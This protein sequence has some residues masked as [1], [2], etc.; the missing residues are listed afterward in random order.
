LAENAGPAGG[1][2]LDTSSDDIHPATARLSAAA[3]NGF[4]RLLTKRLVMVLPDNVGNVTPHSYP[5][6]RK[7]IVSTRPADIALW[8][9]N[10]VR[11]YGCPA[12][13]YISGAWAQTSCPPARHC[14]Q[15][16]LRARSLSPERSSP[17]VRNGRS[18][19]WWASA[20]SRSHPPTSSIR[21]AARR[22]PSPRLHDPDSGCPLGLH[23]W[24]LP[25]HGAT[26]RLGCFVIHIGILAERCGA[27]HV[28]YGSVPAAASTPLSV[29]LTSTGTASWMERPC[30]AGA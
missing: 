19:V 12:G 26:R 29:L 24:N 20:F 23:R 5:S 4:V 3:N 15:D 28:R 14:R 9:Y 25:S 8:Q 7:A 2:A 22:V 6:L 21:R 30:G 1:A 10:C 27:L 11:E 13:V 16:R 17:E 18:P